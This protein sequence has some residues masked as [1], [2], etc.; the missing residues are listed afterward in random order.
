[1]KN[2]VGKLGGC[3]IFSPMDVPLL[4]RK[5]KDKTD[6]SIM[7]SNNNEYVASRETLSNVSRNCM[8]KKRSNSAISNSAEASSFDSL[9]PETL[10]NVIWKIQTRI[11]AKRCLQNQKH[12]LE[13]S[14]IQTCNADKIIQN[15]IR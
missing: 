13:Y 12:A 1:M 9:S 8:W 5:K 7:D 4:L 2:P 3:K 11:A 15:N 14:D 10:S 6:E